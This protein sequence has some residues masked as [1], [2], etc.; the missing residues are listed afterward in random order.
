MNRSY[1]ILWTDV[2]ESDL[3]EI[4]AYIAIDSPSNGLKILKKIKI[5]AASLYRFPERGRIVPELQEQ[6]IH[7]YREVIE[8]PWRIL[9]RISANDVYV[10]SL[11]DSRRNVEDILL[12]RLLYQK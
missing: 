3:R 9:Y 6:G 7:F 11:I 1:R 4:I 2:A 8:T 10:L 5:R 12:K